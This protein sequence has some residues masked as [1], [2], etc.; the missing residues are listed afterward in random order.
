MWSQ[1]PPLSDPA[2]PTMTLRGHSWARFVLRCVFICGLGQDLPSSQNDLSKQTVSFLCYKPTFWQLEMLS[3]RQRN[4][5]PLC[6]VRA[7]VTFVELTA[8]FWVIDSLLICLED[9]GHKRGT[10]LHIQFYILLAIRGYLYLSLG[11][12]GITVNLHLFLYSFY[13]Y[14]QLKQQIYQQL[15]AHS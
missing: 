13:C 1:L 11:T 4:Q 10:T 3:V 8:T 12:L 9:G 7:L 5:Q 14:L 2:Y 6:P 15:S